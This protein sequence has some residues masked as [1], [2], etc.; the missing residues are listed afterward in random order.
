MNLKHTKTAVCD[1]SA[2]NQSSCARSSHLLREQMRRVLFTAAGNANVV[3]AKE[4]AAGER[5]MRY[6]AGASVILDQLT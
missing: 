2:G 6:I 4:P 5:Q 3:D 1:E